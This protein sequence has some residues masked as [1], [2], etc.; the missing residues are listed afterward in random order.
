MQLWQKR[1]SLRK[2]ESCRQDKTFFLHQFNHSNKA[3][4]EKKRNFFEWQKTLHLTK[5]LLFDGKTL[6]LTKSFFFL[7]LEEFYY[8]FCFFTKIIVLKRKAF[9]HRY[10]TS[11]WQ[12]SEKEKIFGGEKKI[13]TF[14][15]LT[16]ELILDA[17]YFVD[18]TRQAAGNG[19]IAH[20]PFRV[21]CT[22]FFSSFHFFCDVKSSKLFDVSFWERMK[23]IRKNLCKAFFTIWWIL[24][25]KTF[26]WKILENHFKNIHRA[27]LYV[28]KRAILL[29]LDRQE[30]VFKQKIFLN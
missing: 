7:S 25:L 14:R 20:F 19:T 27:T 9:S 29:V 24:L 23:I 16:R 3:S 28:N 8:D 6:H 2:R 12:T 17:C 21:G 13:D 5:P 22:Q 11:R 10:A 30:K 26:W 18:K 4:V 1:D 15:S